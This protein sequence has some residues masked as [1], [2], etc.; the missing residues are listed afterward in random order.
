M[1][2]YSKPGIAY[3]YLQDLLGRDVFRNALQEYMNRWKGKHPIPNDFFNSFED[4]LGMDLSWYLKPWFYEKGY[5]DLALKTFN[6]KDRILEIEIEKVGNIPIP[7][8]IS[9][10]KDGISVKEI[11]NTAEVWKSGKRTVKLKLDN[12]GE[13]DRIVLGDVKIPDVNKK[14]NELEGN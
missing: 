8:K 9:L 4:H 2:S 11:Y 6:Y 13:F 12:V 1:A 14:N 3:Q 5:P 10:M 7:I